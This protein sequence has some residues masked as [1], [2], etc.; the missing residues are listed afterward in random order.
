MLGFIRKYIDKQIEHA[1][2][3][4]HHDLIDKL[5]S[6]SDRLFYRSWREVEEQHTAVTRKAIQDYVHGEV[7][8][9]S[10]IERIK[11]KQL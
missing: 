6:K 8:I 11:A 4:E 9:D 7:F 3:T 10:L 5:T 2:C 1:I